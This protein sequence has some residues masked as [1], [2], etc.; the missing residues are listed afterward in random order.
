MLRFL[1]GHIGDCGPGHTT[2][3]RRSVGQWV[4]HS[5]V[6]V[7][8]AS[9]SGQDADVDLENPVCRSREARH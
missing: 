7:D 5:A 4:G 8:A 9:C 6:G 3:I 2:H 1:S